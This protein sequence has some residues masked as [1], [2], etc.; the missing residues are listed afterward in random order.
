MRYFLHFLA[1]SFM[2]SSLFAQRQ[3]DLSQYILTPPAS[4]VLRINGPSVFGVRPGSPFLYT[5]PATGSRPMEF[6][7]EGLPQGLS[8]DHQS[9]R[10]T[11]KLEKAGEYEV[12][13]KV[14]NGVNSAV[15]KFRI[16]AGEEIALTPP[17]GWNSWN[18]WAVGV[19]Q[20]KVL[21]S[22]HILVSSGLINHGWSYVNID[23]SWQGRREGADKALLANEKFPNMK[24]LCE[25]IHAMGLKT[26]IYSTPWITS[27]ANYPGGTAD[28]PKGEW[29]REGLGGDAGH[30]IGRIHFAKA[31]AR[32]YAE[33]GF[34]YLKYDW[35]PNDV[36]STRDMSEALRSTG[37]D[38]V[39]SLSNA[40]PFDKRD[41]LSRWTNVW[42]TTGDIWDHWEPRSDQTY[43]VSLSQIIDS[44]EKWAKV[45]RPGHWNDPD[46]LVV[47]WVSVGSAMHPTHLT[48]DEQYAHISMWCMMSAPLLIGC[49]LTKL[50]DFTLGL[51]TNDEVLAID[52][53]ALG[54][55][56]VRIADLGDVR[57]YQ[58]P[59]EDGASALCF[60]NM[61]EKES[62]VTLD[63]LAGYGFGGRQQVRDLWRQKNLKDAEG[64][65]S[66]TVR[67]HGVMLY[68]L[69][70]R[71]K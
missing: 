23:D 15:R 70:P 45:A 66:A 13:L 32:Q 64:S 24:A 67:P 58:K 40:A 57:V 68:K 7:A 43:H 19:D 36:D 5:V 69:T 65:L 49:N 8:I 3:S 11:G 62:T 25:S 54:K 21:E 71:S 48:P 35:N 31:D 47:G 53:D 50:D 28:N 56:A 39:F 37:R 1:L 22:A 41:E 55:Q 59:M 27:Y 46:M 9:G 51:L 6:A 16:V 33:W 29:S 17:M 14:R 12:I 30:K 63:G 20:K 26:G 42:R 18:S 38:I 61:G 34:D 44:N 60:L 10:I 2:S 52:Q 4:A